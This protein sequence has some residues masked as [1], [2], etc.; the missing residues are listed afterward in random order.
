MPISPLNGGIKKNEYNRL[1]L[2][3]FGTATSPTLIRDEDNKTANTSIRDVIG[4]YRAY[5][6]RTLTEGAA[7]IT[8]TQGAFPEKLPWYVRR[9]TAPSSVPTIRDLAKQQGIK[10]YRLDKRPYMNSQ[11]E[12]LSRLDNRSDVEQ[13]RLNA[14]RTELHCLKEGQSDLFFAIKVPGQNTLLWLSCRPINTLDY[15][16]IVSQ[17]MESEALGSQSTEK[18]LVV[19]G[20]HGDNYGYTVLDQYWNR[21]KYV[22][23]EAFDYA[24][25]EFDKPDYKGCVTVENLSTKS[26]RWLK[27]TM[28]SGTY[29]TIILGWCWS[30]SSALVKEVFGLKLK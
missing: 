13:T 11:I 16:A 2:G 6:I 24:K 5:N 4:K 9:A 26:T 1:G 22:H 3:C 30:D 14:L 19:T 15:K 7:C 12:A 20:S 8:D 21:S 28:Q 17:S 18:I 29:T 10:L 23:Q 27:E 25:H